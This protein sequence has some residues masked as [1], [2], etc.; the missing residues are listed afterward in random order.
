MDAGLPERANLK[1]VYDAGCQI[2]DASGP[3]C[4]EQRFDCPGFRRRSVGALRA[5]AQLVV[6]GF[7]VE[8]GEVYEQLPGF[9]LT[10]F[11]HVAGENDCRRQTRVTQPAKRI[12]GSRRESR[13]WRKEMPVLDACHVSGEEKSLRLTRVM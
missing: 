8:R 7:A 2:L 5:M 13:G 9:A 1:H 6:N 4:L 12:P 11:G 10:D 3:P